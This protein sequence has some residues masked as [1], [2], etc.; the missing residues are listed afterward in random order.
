MNPILAGA[1][2][3]ESLDSVCIECT[4]HKP[5]ASGFVGQRTFVSVDVLGDGE[6]EGPGAILNVGALL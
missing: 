5:E 4:N 1:K 6:M 2:Q 3:T